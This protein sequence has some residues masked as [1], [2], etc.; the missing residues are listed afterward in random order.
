[1]TLLD[2]AGLCVLVFAC[3]LYRFEKMIFDYDCYGVVYDAGSMLCSC[4]SSIFPSSCRPHYSYQPHQRHR[5]RRSTRRY[6]S[7]YRHRPKDNR[8]NMSGIHNRQ[9]Q[10]RFFGTNTAQEENALERVRIPILVLQPNTLHLIQAHRQVSD[11]SLP[12]F[13]PSSYILKFAMLYYLSY[14][15]ESK[16]STGPGNEDVVDNG[17]NVLVISMIGSKLK[18]GSILTS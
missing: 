6:Y 16:Q 14:T 10:Y 1:M 4:F 3:L 9:G 2:I 13:Y 15:I 12:M 11:L 7:S 5:S 8:R 17:P 18:N